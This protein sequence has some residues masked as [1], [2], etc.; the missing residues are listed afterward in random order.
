[1]K[2][3]ISSGF[4]GVIN[5]GSFEN[6]RPAFS[7]EIEY[8]LDKDS[9]LILTI[10]KIQKDLQKVCYDNFK[11]CEEQAIV[12]RVNRERKDIRW[13]TDSTGQK[14][15][16]VTSIIGWDAEMYCS[17]EE[18]AQYASQSNICHKQ[19]EHFIKTGIWAEAKDTPDTWADIVIVKKGN[20]T[21]D[22]EG[23]SFPD[24][25]KKY[26]IL[27][28]KNKGSSINEEF[29]YGGTPDF[30]GI[31]D[32]KGAEKVLTLFDVKRTV[33]KTKAFKQLSAYSKM[34]GFEDVKQICIVPLNNKTEQGFS[35]P[36]VENRIEQYF[37]MFLKDR[38]NF[39][40]RFGV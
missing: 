1:M 25:L 15:P 10:D 22:T 2:I 21:L 40:S 4:T 27:E 28:M 3:K 7:A 31:P 13:Y 32:F 19:V 36:V 14:V 24:F 6:S 30:I 38:E 29:K 35:K 26:P 12:E 9:P 16:S 20:L 34:K 23:W 8:D 39:K 17:P 37:S 18:L 33:D 11:A 5:R